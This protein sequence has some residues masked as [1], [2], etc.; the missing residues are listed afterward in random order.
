MNPQ[1]LAKAFADKISY[2]VSDAQ[3]QGDT[4]LVATRISIPDF[5]E[6][7]SRGLE[8]I[9]TQRVAESGTDPMALGE[10]TLIKLLS[11]TVGEYLASSSFPMKSNDPTIEYVWKNGTW[12]IK[13]STDFDR[14]LAELMGSSQTW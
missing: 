5:S 2:G 11:D 3:V 8:E 12:E 14:A 1:F 4:A 6:G 10:A 9:S 13:D 7:A